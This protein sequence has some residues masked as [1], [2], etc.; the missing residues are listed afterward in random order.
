MQLFQVKSF[1]I[2]AVAFCEFH[3]IEAL[4]SAAGCYQDKGDNRAMPEILFTDRGKLDWKDL[5]GTVIEK[6]EEAAKSKNYKCFGIQFYGECWSGEDACD[7]YDKHGKSKDC[8]CSGNNNNNKK[9]D[10]DSDAPCIGGVGEQY[11]N[12]VYEIV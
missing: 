7:E 8:S 11:T 2:L 6:C 10:E 1:L 4:L 9:Y 5:S 3:Y 12:F